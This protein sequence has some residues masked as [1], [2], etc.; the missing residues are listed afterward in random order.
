[1]TRIS[2]TMNCV[3]CASSRD[4]EFPHD[5]PPKT[6]YCS[7]CRKTTRHLVDRMSTKIVEEG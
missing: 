4:V 5:N 6:A 7:K 1:M 2:A 3:N